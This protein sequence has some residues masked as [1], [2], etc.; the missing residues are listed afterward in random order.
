MGGLLHIFAIG[1]SALAFSS[2]YNNTGASDD[3]N[4]LAANYDSSG[5]SHSVEALQTA[6]ITPGNT[7]TFNN[8]AFTWPG[9]LSGIANNYIVQGQI[10]PVTPV[11]GA[12]TLAFLGS[13][14]NGN[15]SGTATITSTDGSTQKFTLGMSDWTLGGG[16]ALTAFGNAIVANCL[17]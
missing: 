16:K 15:T 5:Y 13:A 7:V 14:T 11:N 4:T 6:G 9:A 1:T 3:T 8:V 12:Q 2:A 10:V 17:L